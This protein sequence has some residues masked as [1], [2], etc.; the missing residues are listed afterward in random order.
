MVLQQN[1]NLKKARTFLFFPD[2]AMMDFYPSLIISK[3]SIPDLSPVVIKIQA[4][5]LSMFYLIHV[6][7]WKLV[8]KL[9]TRLMSLPPTIQ[10]TI[11]YLSNSLM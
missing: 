10:I 1:F 2:E 7:D 3:G 9:F 6:K 4:H 5:A 8:R 11:P